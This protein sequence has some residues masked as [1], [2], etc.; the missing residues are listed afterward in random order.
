M[1][2]ISSNISTFCILL[3]LLHMCTTILHKYMKLLGTDCHN[4]SDNTHVQSKIYREFSIGI[5]YIACG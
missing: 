5:V 1:E 4:Y 3:S 2:S